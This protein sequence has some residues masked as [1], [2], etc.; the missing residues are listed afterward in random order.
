MRTPNRAVSTRATLL[1]HDGWAPYERF[2]EARH[3]Q[4]LAHLLRR[5]GELLDV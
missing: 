1:V 4:C 3:Q 2:V 5:C